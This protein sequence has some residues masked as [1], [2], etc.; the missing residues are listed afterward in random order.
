MELKELVFKLSCAD[1]PSG[2]EQ[3][4]A[5]LAG[6]LLRPYVDEVFEDVMGNVIGVR[7]TVKKNAKKLLLDAHIDEVGLIIT[8]CDEGF[9][10]FSSLGGIDARVLPAAEVRILTDPPIYGVISTMP[11]HVLSGEDM[12]KPIKIEDMVI[13]AGLT[14]EDSALVAPGTPAV[15]STTPMILHG[16]TICGKALDDRLCFAVILGALGKLGKEDLGFELYVM[17]SVQEELGLRGAKTGAFGVDP[18]Y[19][20]ALDVTHAAT[21]DHDK[22]G[23]MRL[24]EGVV[25]GIGPAMDRGLSS[26]LKSLAGER[27]IPYQIEVEPGN[28]GANSWAIQVSRSGVPTGLLSVPLRYMHSPVETASL[29]DAEAASCLLYE[30]IRQFEGAC[31]SCLKQ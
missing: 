19:C 8:G 12:D 29:S 21:P 17:A 3:R 10:K 11:P 28:P 20:I 18:D 7:R 5:G 25:I 24:G 22:D 1:G 9:L 31:A 15:F 27:G 23:V 14:E 26:L 6:D 30:F 4:A 16:D 13:D 2:Y